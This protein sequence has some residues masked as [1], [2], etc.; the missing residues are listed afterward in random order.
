V[1]LRY[2]I[3]VHLDRE[4]TKQWILENLEEVVD[5]ERREWA[6]S[7]YPSS[8]R[9]MGVKVPDQRIVVKDLVKRLKGEEAAEIILLCKEL[10]DMNIFECQQ[11]AYE[12]LEKMK[13]IRAELTFDD[14]MDL[15][16][17]LDN[18][19]SVDTFSGYISGVA[20]REGTISDDVI[21]EWSRS[22]DRWVRRVALVSTLGLNQKARGG[23]GDVD[24]T[25]MVCE[26]LKEDHDDMVVKA[27]S[28]ALRELSK[29]DHDAASRFLEDNQEVLHKRVVRELSTKLRTGRKNG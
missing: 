4:S 27:M 14:I 13:K 1:I 3:G 29:V 11:V 8:M 19:V 28:W 24:R 7:Y 12:I 21:M 10:V 22:D 20:W 2:P 18:W 17:G 6:K 25:L 16:K 9:V 23:T 5:E 26:A 15:M